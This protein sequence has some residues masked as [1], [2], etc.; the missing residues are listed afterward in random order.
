MSITYGPYSIWLLDQMSDRSQGD[1]VESERK[2]G[3][4]DEQSSL[5]ILL[6]PEIIKLCDFL[7][8]PV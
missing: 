5:H 7:L 1:N 6:K 8:L 2:S 3:L 4:H